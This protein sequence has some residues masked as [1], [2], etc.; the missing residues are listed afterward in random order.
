MKLVNFKLR[1]E[2]IQNFINLFNKFN[3]IFDD[4]RNPFVLGFI[5]SKLIYA[6]YDFKGLKIFKIKTQPA[7][8]NINIEINFA[9]NLS[10]T[11]G[12]MQRKVIWD[13][14]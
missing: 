10:K 13:G 4:L 2:N 11:K 8:H 6:T 14:L 5:P 12:K 1:S 9:F 3:N 7:I